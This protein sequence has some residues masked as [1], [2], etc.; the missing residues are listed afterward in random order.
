[1]KSRVV[2]IPISNALVEGFLNQVLAPLDLSVKVNH[3]GPDPELPYRTL[4]EAELRTK[5]ADEAVLPYV[6]IEEGH[7]TPRVTVIMQVPV[8]GVR[9]PDAIEIEVFD[10]V[11]GK[12][13]WRRELEEKAVEEV[14]EGET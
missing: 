13:L 10:P 3:I 5:G 6:G 12:T 7:R 2:F 8:E 1:M 4:V 9:Y 11:S 14:V